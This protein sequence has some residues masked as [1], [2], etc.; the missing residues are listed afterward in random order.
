[1]TA[2]VEPITGE[3]EL[4][5]SD[6]VDAL[7]AQPGSRFKAMVGLALSATAIAV[8]VR[9]TPEGGSQPLPVIALLLAAPLIARLGK[10]LVAQRMYRGMRPS[11]RQLAL[12]VSERGLDVKLGSTRS[13]LSWEQVL[14]SREGQRTWL[15]YTSPTAFIVVPKRAFKADLLGEALK[16]HLQGGVNAA[17]P[18]QPQLLLWALLL[19]AALLLATV[20]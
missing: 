2:S 19:G 14:T 4:E 7:D 12:T 15:I 16:R 20:L 13:H 11:E 9:A 10:R 5:L 6:V 17:R 8:V 1:M 18:W 3:A